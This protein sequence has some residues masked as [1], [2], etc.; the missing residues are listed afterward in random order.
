MALVIQNFDVETSVLLVSSISLGEIRGKF[1]KEFKE[2]IVRQFE[3]DNDYDLLTDL[4]MEV[5]EKKYLFVSKSSIDVIIMC[6]CRIETN[7]LEFEENRPVKK[8]LGKRDIIEFNKLCVKMNLVGVIVTDLNYRHCVKR[9]A[10]SLN[11]LLTRPGCVKVNID[12]LVEE[13]IFQMNE[14]STTTE[15]EEEI[16]Y[17]QKNRIIY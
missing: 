13:Q 8:R 17:F 5:D 1:Y 16:R 6:I 7:L 12:N 3:S 11:I 15:D 2:I 10:R 9:K 14:T 4:I